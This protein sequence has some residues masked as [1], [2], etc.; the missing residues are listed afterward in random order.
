MSTTLENQIIGWRARSG[1]RVPGAGL[2]SS[3]LA[4]VSIAAAVLYF[5]TTSQTAA[6][7][8]ALARDSRP[9][10]AVHATMERPSPVTV[11]IRASALAGTPLQP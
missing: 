2:L 8:S 9:P 5:A 1:I 3:F 10:A 4:A 6:V 11:T 7:V